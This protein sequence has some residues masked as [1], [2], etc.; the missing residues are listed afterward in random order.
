MRF[1]RLPAAAALALALGGTATALATTP[2]LAA[3]PTPTEIIDFIS[4][5]AQISVGH[6]E[7]TLSGRV[8]ET[9][10]TSVGVPG[11]KVDPSE[12]I[13]GKGTPEG[14]PTVTTGAD[15]TFKFQLSATV[16]GFFVASSEPGPGYAASSNVPSVKVTS[17]GEPTRVTLNPQPKSLV[18]SGT[19]LTFTGK[20]EAEASDGQ[21]HPLVTSP[22]DADEIGISVNGILRDY[23]V[24]KAD[25]TF[26]V[27]L[28]AFDGGKWQAAVLD[29]WGSTYGLYRE[30]S[31][32][33]VVVEAQHRTQ[34]SSWGV[35]V[36][37]AAH[38]TV[39]ITGMVQ[40][41]YG[42]PWRGVPGLAVTYYYRDLPS[43]RWIKAGSAKTNADGVF[44][45]TLTAKAGH[46]RWHVVVA[47]Q[48]LSGD[49]YLATT[50]GT[51]DTVIKG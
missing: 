19:D 31:S 8:V 2:A 24:T 45:S 17:A 11:A 46:L 14:L 10:H 4:S 40:G 51:H 47:R 37:S 21:W 32:T 41:Q 12:I 16:G 1:S 30:S 3:S 49:V 6:T 35:A 7:I 15:G 20:A 18:W 9:D 44:K 28:P 43:T 27:K 48:D 50:T 29:D 13:G 25:G 36:K 26:T 38:H 34:V 39:A 33:A 5:P 23:A 22:A 42:T